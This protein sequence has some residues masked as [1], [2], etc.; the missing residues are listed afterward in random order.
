MLEQSKARGAVRAGRTYRKSLDFGLFARPGLV[1]E[2]PVRGE[3]PDEIG[4]E[5]VVRRRSRR[6][7]R[8]GSGRTSCGRSRAP[9]GRRAA[10]VR[11]PVRRSFSRLRSIVRT[12]SRSDLDEHRRGG[13][14]RERLEP[15][16]PRARKEIEHGRPVDRA[17]Q[18]EGCLAHAVGGRP[19]VVALR[20]EDPRSAVL[21][22]DDPHA[23][24]PRC[25]KRAVR[26]VAEEDETDELDLRSARR[27]APTATGAASVDRVAVDAGR[28]RRES[29]RRARRARRRRAAP[30]RGTRRAAPPGRRDRRV[31]PGRRCGSP[32]AP[33]GR[34]R[35]SRPPG[36]SAG[37]PRT[38][39]RGRAG[40]PR[41]SPA[42]RAR[43]I[44][45][46]TPPPPSS[47]RVGGVDD[48]V[49]RLL[50]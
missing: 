40:T 36:L 45:P 23:R 20:R 34:R 17:D 49:D 7:G 11:A 47:D 4:R 48:R 16:R 18:V 10:R 8:R 29:D 25:G 19:R 37:R 30:R 46:S 26:V 14:A 15:H 43:W 1:D 12:A 32:S 2:Q 24:H 3:R 13:A 28:D 9:G 41:G 38:A 33:A 6:A 35:S 42:R 22:G 44:A 5:A 31:R 50:A 27:T 21:A 39:P